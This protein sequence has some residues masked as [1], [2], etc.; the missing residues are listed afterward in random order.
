[1]SPNPDPVDSPELHAQQA[2]TWAEADTGGVPHRCMPPRAVL[3]RI[4]C[5]AAVLVAVE[6]V[7]V[8]LVGHG[9]AQPPRYGDLAVDVGSSAV[10][11]M[12]V[13]AQ[14]RNSIGWL[15]RRSGL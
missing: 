11:L 6:I 7:V 8:L 3:R 1:M 4:G 14:P 2:W 10:G 15:M 13:G 12:L 5:W 9:S